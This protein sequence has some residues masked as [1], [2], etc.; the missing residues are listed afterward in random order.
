[1]KTREQ[2]FRI[3][4]ARDCDVVLADDSVSRHHAELSYIDGDKLFLTDCH[5][6]NGT[7]LVAGGRET[8][9]RQTLLSPTET[10]RFGDLVLSVEEL[11]EAIRL[12]FPVPGT[13]DPADS[14]GGAESGDDP[15]SSRPWA[16][17]DVVR[18]ACGAVKTRDEP[19]PTCGE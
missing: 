4:R 16:R 6:S 19:C 7:A 3:G 14:P 17:G 18:C 5:S 1:M 13:A 2:T 12:K 8:P 11:L 10:V 9:V 15:P